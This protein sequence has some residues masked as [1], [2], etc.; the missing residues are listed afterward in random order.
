MTIVLWSLAGLL[1]LSG[2]AGLLLPALPGPPLLFAGL[3]CAAWAED[4]LYVGW[5]T[6]ALL[7]VLALLAVVADFIAGAFGARHFGASTRAMAGAAIGALVGLFFG[8][9]G[10]LL[11]PFFGAM[12]GE[13]TARADLQAASRAGIGAVIGL[14]VGT[15]AKM[16]LAVAMLGVFLAVRLL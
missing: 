7:G 10:L 2:F 14:A 1:V 3:L 4:F 15:A 12:A 13:L 8:L 9:P 16:A 11:G 6:L 5:R